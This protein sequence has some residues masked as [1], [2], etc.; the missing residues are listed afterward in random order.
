MGKYKTAV[1]AICKNEIKHAERFMASMSEADGVYILD[2]GSEDGSAERLADLGAHVSKAVISPWRF[3][4]ARNLALSL[5]PADTDIC[6]CCDMDEVFLPG[7]REE[8]EK[9]WGDGVNR[10]SYPF[11]Y[12]EEGGESFFY[13]SLIHGRRGFKWQYPIHE[14]LF[15]VEREICRRC[16][17][18]RL[19]HRPDP[20]KSREEYLTLLEQAVAETPDDPRMNHYLGREYMY[21]GMWEKAISVLSHHVDICGW[22][23]ER[24]ASLR[25]MGR[26]LE[27][28]DNPEE[29]E[30]RYR[31][32][33]LA[34]PYIKEPHVELAFFLYSNGRYEE[35]LDE[36]QKAIA[37]TSPHD[38]YFNEAFA[39]GS[40]PFDIAAICAYQGGQYADALE[41][42]KKA[43]ELS[44]TDQRLAMNVNFIQNAVIFS[45][46][47]G[48]PHG[49]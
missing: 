6:V 20:Q 46:G 18:I 43:L 29:A 37:V 27:K 34:C 38:S 10:L 42:A 49:C 32:A 17:T 3:D 5:V 30:N 44:P 21:R 14:A 2:T 35:A 12:S 36:A 26:C 48:G 39:H 7:W 45:A 40:L 13:R 47:Q 1:Y 9:Y 25:Y 41:Y 22:D 15:C 33:V 19:Y 8:A 31:Q 16:D 28:L 4:R 23:A 24:C 11:V